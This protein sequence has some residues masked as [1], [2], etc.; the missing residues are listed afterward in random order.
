MEKRKTRPAGVALPRSPD[1]VTMADAPAPADD[2]AYIRRTYAHFAHNGVPNDGVD[3]GE[4]H[5]RHKHAP[6]LWDAPPACRILPAHVFV[7]DLARQQSLDRFGFYDARPAHVHAEP[8]VLPRKARTAAKPPSAAHVQHVRSHTA[9]ARRDAR[10]VAKWAHMLELRE[11]RA[12]LRAP[13]AVVRRRV[14]KGIPDAWRGAVWFALANHPE[15]RM[16][17]D[18]LRVPSMHDVQIDLDV[19]RT[20]RGHVHFHPRYGRGQ[21]DLFTGLHAAS[22][23][24]DECGYCQGMGPL[25]GVLLLYMVPADAYAMLA[26]LHTKYAFHDLFRPGFPGLRAELFVLRALLEHYTPRAARAL[27]SCGVAPSAFAT[28]WYMTLFSGVMPFATQLRLWD[29]FLLDGRDVIT[30]AALAVVLA[31]EPRLGTPPTDWA[32]EALSA[33]I[34]PESDD[35]LLQWIATR[36]DDP[37]TQR[38]MRDA[39]AAWAAHCADDTA[40]D[41][42]L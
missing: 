16:P 25:L 23:L 6:P 22:L 30:L 21:C 8:L 37:R 20:M 41:I 1:R 3:A 5:T 33:P 2:G 39:R 27:A 31:I 15:A 26:Q 9:D 10:R 17:D 7:A 12:Y 32:V 35:A 13:P 40:D 38:I 24:C 36:L 11:G 42:F 34:L 29:A 18:P 19:P 14:Y 4:E 28:G